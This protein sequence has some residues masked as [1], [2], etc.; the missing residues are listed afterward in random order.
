MKDYKEYQ[1]K[2]KEWAKTNEPQGLQEC[3]RDFDLRVGDKVTYTNDYGVE[4]KGHTIVGFTNDHLLFKYGN[5]VYLD[6]D[7]Y[8]FPVKP[9]SLRKEVS[10]ISFEQLRE[11]LP[12]EM[13]QVQ[14]T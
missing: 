1:G 12:E 8:W 6:T 3:P 9:E 2:F 14:R 7:S 4:F 5:C 11:S 13:A 10:E